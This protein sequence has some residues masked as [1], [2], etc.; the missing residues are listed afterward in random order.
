MP[1][2]GASAE[3]T[4]H[5]HKVTLAHS[6]PSRSPN[7][8]LSPNS[9]LS[10]GKKLTEGLQVKDNKAKGKEAEV[11][12]KKQTISRPPIRMGL[13][14]QPGRRHHLTA[15]AKPTI[16]KPRGIIQERQKEHATEAESPGSDF[17]RKRE[18][19]Q[20]ASGLS[21]SVSKIRKAMKRYLNYERMQRGTD[22]FFTGIIE[23]VC[24]ELL[25]GA[26]M[27]MEASKKKRI[28]PRHIWLAIQTDEELKQL[29]GHGVIPGAGVAPHIHPALLDPAG[30]SKKRA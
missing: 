28:L 30:R 6:P 19:M 22:V 27:Q 25:E 3:K 17:R 4:G 8:I 14:T 9:V 23:C 7:S 16:K 12:A 24:Q 5:A 11:H 1:D 15:K 2:G 20:Q 21:F 26:R 29:L 18:T 10:D 13:R